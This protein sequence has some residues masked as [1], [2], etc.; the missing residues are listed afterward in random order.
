M[1]FIDIPT[2]QTTAATDV[3]LAIVALLVCLLTYRAGK[4]N[5]PKKGKIWAWAFGLLAF[6]AMT[7]AVAHGFQMPARLNYILWQPLNLALGLTVSLFVV[8]VVFDLTRGHLPRFVLPLLI[9]AGTL[10]YLVTLIF[11]GT[12]LVFILYEA[13]AMLF[14][15]IV[16]ILLGIRNRVRGAWLMALGIFI[17]MIAAAIQ[18][19]ESVQVHCIWDFDHNGIFH[20]V[21]IAGLLVL[22][23]G[24]RKDLRKEEQ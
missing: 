8:G 18:A 19:S 16:Y 1:T 15:L 5:N 4:V 23:A 10:F 20:I 9:T 2:E 12:F 14:A 3:V 17:T 7:G 22:F 11:P 13:V 24:L 21:Q 6:A